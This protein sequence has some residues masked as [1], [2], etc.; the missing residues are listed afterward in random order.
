MY[1]GNCRAP[2]YSHCMRTVA[3]LQRLG[4][5]NQSDVFILLLRATVIYT[6]QVGAEDRASS[7]YNCQSLSYFPDHLLRAESMATLLEFKAEDGCGIR[8]ITVETSLLAYIIRG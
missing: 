3:T 1:F 2:Q 5:R 6:V 8:R 7:H 4:Y